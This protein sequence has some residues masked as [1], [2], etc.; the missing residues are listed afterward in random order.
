[1]SWNIFLLMPLKF[2]QE[3]SWWLEVSKPELEYS[4][5]EEE[6]MVCPAPGTANF[7]YYSHVSMM[8]SLGT[9]FLTRYL[10]EHVT[11]INIIIWKAYYFPFAFWQSWLYDPLFSPIIACFHVGPCS[12][13]LS[14]SLACISFMLWDSLCCCAIAL[15]VQNL[16]LMDVLCSEMK[17]RFMG[18]IAFAAWIWIWIGWS[19]KFPNLEFLIYGHHLCLADPSLF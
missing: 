1:M 2:E 14:L 7:A 17:F 18:M 3:N 6:K 8:Y 12:L 5:I 15:Y 9:C 13:S 10:L 4:C 19:L 11:S 16:D